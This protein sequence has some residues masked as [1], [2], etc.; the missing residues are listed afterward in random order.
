MG[1]KQCTRIIF[2]A[3]L[4]RF[5]TEKRLVT[6]LAREPQAGPLSPTMPR[7]VNRIASEPANEAVAASPSRH[8]FA[9]SR[10]IR[11]ITGPRG[12]CLGDIVSLSLPPSLLMPRY[13][14]KSIVCFREGYDRQRFLR[15]LIAGITV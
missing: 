4:R 2:R 5:D 13:L 6:P 1:V 12:N 8:F 15:D 9:S 7:D 11:P 14:P 3:S 10:C